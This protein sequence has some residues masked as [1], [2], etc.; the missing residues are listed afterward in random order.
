[1]RSSRKEKTFLVG[2]SFFYVLWKVFFLCVEQKCEIA[3]I[4]LYG[5]IV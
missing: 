4:K 1:M 3:F 5:G 2:R